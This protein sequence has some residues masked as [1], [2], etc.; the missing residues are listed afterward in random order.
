VTNT[1]TY[2][3]RALFAKEEAR[4]FVKEAK[5]HPYHYVLDVRYRT[6]RLALLCQE[7]IGNTGFVVGLDISLDIIRVT[8]SRVFPS[9]LA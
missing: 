8:K 2:N 9:H 6:G 7:A 5:L 1:N 4:V 3:R